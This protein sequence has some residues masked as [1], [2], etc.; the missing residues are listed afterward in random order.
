[1]SMRTAW[2]WAN[3][4]YNKWQPCFK[5]KCTNRREVRRD[6]T[7][8]FYT[9]LESDPANSQQEEEIEVS[10]VQQQERKL[11]QASDGHQPQTIWQERIRIKGEHSKEYFQ[12]TEDKF[13]LTST[14]QNSYLL[15]AIT[16]NK[17]QGWNW[18]ERI[19][20]AHLARRWLL[21]QAGKS[22]DTPLSLAN[23]APYYH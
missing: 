5:N 1:M 16:N 19:W 21:C 4:S 8:Q 6:L 18:A 11:R 22:E 9:T 2:A 3:K 12:H 10:Q 17:D 7:S 23:L 13:R 15:S 20:P 14:S